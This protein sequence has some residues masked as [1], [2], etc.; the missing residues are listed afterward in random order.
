MARQWGLKVES[1]LILERLDKGY[2]TL[3]WFEEF[4]NGRIIHEPILVSDHAAILYDSDPTTIRSTRPY[5][6]E[7]WCLGFSEV[8]NI[9]DT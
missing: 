8:K 5:Q 2:V 1:D 4:P 9:I 6:L 7:L 3:E